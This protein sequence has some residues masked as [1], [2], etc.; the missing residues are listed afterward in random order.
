MTTTPAPQA[1]SE[2]SS[3]TAEPVST[4]TSR[5]EDFLRTSSNRIRFPGPSVDRKPAASKLGG[6]A[7]RTSN[8]GAG[9]D[10]DKKPFWWFPSGWEV[11]TKQKERPVLLRFWTKMPLIPDSVAS[12][13]RSQ[14]HVARNNRE[15]SKSP[16]DSL[17]REVAFQD[18]SKAFQGSGGSRIGGS[19]GETI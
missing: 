8:V 12:R 19:E 18:I 7:S 9:A 6:I 5:F 10:K 14:S 16:S 1:T 2:T 13:R 17:Y 11:D 4:T 3:T 15:N